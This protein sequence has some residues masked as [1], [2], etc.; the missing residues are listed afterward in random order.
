MDA[1]SW[2]RANRSMRLHFLAG[3]PGSTRKLRLFAAA[4]CR[5][6]WRWLGDERCRRAVEVAERSA[7]DPVGRA[8][9]SAAVR[10]AE[11]AL[12][13]AV[14]AS[15]AVSAGIDAESRGATQAMMYGARTALYCLTQDADTTAEIAAHA[16]ACTV[17]K[18]AVASLAWVAAYRAACQAEREVQ[19]GLLDEVFGDPFRPLIICRDWLT[20]DVR[21]LAR[22]IY[23]EQR[24]SEVPV[25]ADALEDAGCTEQRLLGH[26]RGPEG[27][28]RGCF[29]VDLLRG[30][31]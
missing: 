19:Q 29:V 10:A 25:L 3:Q 4:C 7:D 1:L 22:V 15:N 13:D 8:E 17:P 14:I 26:L 9:V 2:Q 30:Q 12:R 11:E 28:V 23:G 20:A 21:G 16:A 6:V 31:V 27:H 5:R 18:M 24:F